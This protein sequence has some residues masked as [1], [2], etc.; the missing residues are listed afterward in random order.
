VKF[1]TGVNGAF[2]WL[3]TEH[4]LD[5]LLRLRPDVVVGK[6]LAIT[7]IDSGS[8]FI[9]EQLKSA[10]WE[11]RNDIAYSPLIQSI[12]GLPHDGYDEWYVFEAPV[13][14]GEVSHGNPFEAPIKRGQ[15]HVIVNYG[16]VVLCDPDMRGLADLFWKQMEWIN[17]ESYLGDSHDTLTFVT[18]NKDL[19]NPVCQA[20]SDVA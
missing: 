5:V 4:E 8:L 7:S 10:G 2:Q 16:G 19:F 14:L 17:P 13:D 3:T 18:R 6:Y 12:E 15:V 20:L 11:S 9:N 1:T